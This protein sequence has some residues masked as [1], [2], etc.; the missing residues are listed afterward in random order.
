MARVL[1]DRA[2]QLIPFLPLDPLAEEGERINEENRN[3]ILTLITRALHDATVEGLMPHNDF[4]LPGYAPDFQ[5]I[6]MHTECTPTSGPR[7]GSG[8]PLGGRCGI[9]LLRYRS[10]LEAHW[11]RTWR[12]RAGR[13]A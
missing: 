3:S 11:K 5:P 8:I 2:P 12:A 13:A 7:W 4:T 6:R 9:A 1:R 10:L